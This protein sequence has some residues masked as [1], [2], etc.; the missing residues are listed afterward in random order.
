MWVSMAVAGCGCFSLGIEGDCGASSGGAWGLQYH[1]GTKSPKCWACWPAA[2][3]LQG[4]LGL[5]KGV[6]LTEHWQVLVLGLR[7]RSIQPEVGGRQG[8]FGRPCSGGFS[9]GPLVACYLGRAREFV[10]PHSP[11]DSGLQRTACGSR[12]VKKEGQALPNRVCTQ[13]RQGC[14]LI[15]RLVRKHC[16]N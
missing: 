16:Q 14:V 15:V 4:L 5:L 2:Q 12:R 8:G 6:L 10:R 1:R 11:A 3:P 7:G 13:K 9:W